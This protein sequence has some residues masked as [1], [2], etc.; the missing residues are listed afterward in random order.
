[1]SA[2][3]LCLVRF[4][5]CRRLAARLLPQK[6]RL[7]ELALVESVRVHSAERGIS[8]SYGALVL[9]LEEFRSL[10]FAPHACASQQAE[11]F[12]RGLRA[13][14]HDPN[15]TVA[16][17]LWRTSYVQAE[18]MIQ[19]RRADDFVIPQHHKHTHMDRVRHPAIT[20]PP[21]TETVISDTLA[22][23]RSDAVSDLR[24]VGITL[25]PLSTLPQPAPL[26]DEPLDT[27][28]D[29][30]VVE[31][32]ELVAG[33]QSSFGETTS[34]EISTS[35]PLPPSASPLSSFLLNNNIR[36]K[37]CFSSRPSR[38]VPLPPSSSTVS[39]AHGLLVN[40]QQACALVS[41]HPSISAD[42]VKRVR[43]M[44]QKPAATAT[45]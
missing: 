4:V 6:G 27:V 29:D 7:N 31:E 42:R 28:I 10:P 34:D 30:V 41:M 9:I 40:K 38:I 19:R 44:E 26:V 15:F 11:E 22:R 13:M 37:D 5:L 24:A 23:A 33:D 3:L 21:V 2:A 35:A 43:K 18:A 20:L 17:C 12:F 39:D 8:S 32:C 14:F 1:M 16:G 36:L 25:P 45:V